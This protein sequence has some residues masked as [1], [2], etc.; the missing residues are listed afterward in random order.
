M[1]NEMIKKQGEIPDMGGIFSTPEKFESAIRMA[2]SLSK[3]TMVP[4]EFQENVSNCVIAV[5][6][7]ERTKMSPFM[8]M[9]NIYVVYGKPSWSSQFVGALINASRRYKEP[10]H[11]EMNKEKTACRAWSIDQNG[12]R[13]EGP[14][15]TIQMAKDEGWYSKNGS[16]WKTMPEI[17]LRYRALSFFGR[18]YCGDLLVGM[19]TQDEA[20]EM[21]EQEISVDE[22]ISKN[23][24]K[25]GEIGFD[26]NL[27][28]EKASESENNNFGEKSMEQES[29][30][31]EIP[32]SEQHDRQ[33]GFEADF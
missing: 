20:I 22:E 29:K 17:M 27:I 32:Q 3:S 19:Y 30:R 1:S 4:K 6:M 18:A 23:A 8:V 33:M 26:E 14:E 25:G 31:K 5:D 9:Q 24:N 7:A 13:V 15:V 21:N 11:Y 10:I 2:T 16:K 12:N 28:D